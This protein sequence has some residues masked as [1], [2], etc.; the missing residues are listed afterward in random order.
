MAIRG[1]PHYTN[2]KISEYEGLGD[3]AV[4]EG[5]QAPLRYTELCRFFQAGRC[6]RGG[7]CNFAHYQS[8]LRPKPTLHRT[9][10]CD[11]FMSTG[12]CKFGATCNHAHGEHELRRP[13]G[14]PPPTLQKVNT[15]NITSAVVTVEPAFSALPE[16]TTSLML[17]ETVQDALLPSLTWESD[18]AKW[19]DANT[20]TLL[21]RLMNESTPIYDKKT[22]F[23]ISVRNSFLHF[24]EEGESAYATRSSLTRSSSSY[25]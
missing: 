19:R 8:E 24:E 20:V 3:H 25:L 18:D 11:L 16:P 14:A 7:N 1:G 4:R 21:H 9:K 6:K 12:T 17:A 2:S 15:R 10:L 23:L 5:R 22:Q 13:E